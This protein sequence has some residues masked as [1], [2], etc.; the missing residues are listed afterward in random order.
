MLTQAV[1][2]RLADEQGVGTI[3]CLQE[4]RPDVIARLMQ[5]LLLC[6][7]VLQEGSFKAL[8]PQLVQLAVP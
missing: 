1:C 4:V 7:Q 2:H 3:F 6:M 8:E 5:P